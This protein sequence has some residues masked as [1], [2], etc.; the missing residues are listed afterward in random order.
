MRALLALTA[1]VSLTLGCD[2][3]AAKATKQI[4]PLD[5]VPAVVIKA[6][7]GR[8]PEV[9]FD[10]VIKADGFYEVRGKGKNGKIVEVEVSETGE[11]LQV[12]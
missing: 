8:M 12:E 10:T 7:Q 9:N 3:G 6:A 5:S 1:A 2:Q 4:V 11:V